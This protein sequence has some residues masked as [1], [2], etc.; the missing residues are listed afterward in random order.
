LAATNLSI[1]G[2]FSADGSAG[3][4]GQ[5]L[6]SQGSG[7]PA[8]WAYNTGSQDLL[9]VL[10][11]GNTGNRSIILENL[12]SRI[13]ADID[14]IYGTSNI[15]VLDKGTSNSSTLS[16]SFVRVQGS[17]NTAS[18][19]PNK[20]RYTLSGNY[21]DILASN[22]NNQTFI[23]P[24]NGGAFVMSVNGTYAD[25]S[26][27]VTITIPSPTA[28]TLQDVTEQ[29]NTTDKGINLIGEVL[30]PIIGVIL[31]GNDNSLVIAGQTNTAGFNLVPLTD[32]RTYDLPDSN[33]TLA[34]LSDIPS[35]A[36][37][38]PYTGATSNVQLG[39][40]SI[41]SDNGTY[42]T[43]MSP[44]FFGVQNNAQTIFG[45]LEYDKVQ[46]TD[47]VLSKTMTI[48]ATGL[49]FP[50]ATTQTTAA[51]TSVGATSP[52][53]SSGGAT[54]TISTSMAT[55]K[56]IGRSTVGIGVMEEI[57]VGTGLSLSGGTLNAT[58]QVVGF[59]QNFLLMGA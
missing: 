39:V 2:T 54:P 48:A 12:S 6:T 19:Q 31:M 26:G 45:T 13:V 32:S 59:E 50:D 5:V 14:N 9:N 49:T 41:T 1:S 51:V 46:L 21:I 3:L 53:T 38:V 10:T 58:A 42:N 30:N 25:M 24:T 18:Y 22:F 28:P 44:L 16:S 35:P 37:F 33:G 15:Y 29:G 34:L 11:N 55:N 52:I 23:Y 57:S 7:S 17:S 8:V 36:T 40:H 47:S 20:I 27:N 56:L 4:V 43:E